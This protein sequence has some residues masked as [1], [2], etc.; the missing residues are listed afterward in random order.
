MQ[1]ELWPQTYCNARSLVIGRC[2][3]AHCAQ[4]IFTCRVMILYGRR[5]LATAYA[6][7]NAFQTDFRATALSRL[8]GYGS[9]SFAALLI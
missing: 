9:Y 6:P 2:K 3:Y 8:M 7:R 1:D 5:E 4:N